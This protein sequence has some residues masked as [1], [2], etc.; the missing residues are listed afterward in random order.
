MIIN[1]RQYAFKIDE[2]EY[3][4]ALDVTQQFMGG[5]WKPVVLWYLRNQTYRFGELKSQ[6]PD[7]TEKMLSI[8]LKQLE[9]QGLVQ[10]AVFDE[11]PPRTE[12]SL[13]NRGKSLVPLL[14][15]MARWG[16]EYAEEN[17][18]MIEK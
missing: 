15:E 2:K 13:T 17:G 10:K 4:C 9:E 7:I 6:I 14:N 3:H 12:Y 16:R 18:E 8:Q 11:V 5:K 1:Q